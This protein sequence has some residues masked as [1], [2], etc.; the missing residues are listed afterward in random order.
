MGGKVGV[1][2]WTDGW[3]DVLAVSSNNT[4][5]SGTWNGRRRAL[6]SGI[7]TWGWEGTSAH[8]AVTAV[9]DVEQ[10][11]EERKLITTSHTFWKLPASLLTRG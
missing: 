1:D 6:G 3:M 5:S 9:E 7:D 11:T 8:R 2:G 10:A 4:N